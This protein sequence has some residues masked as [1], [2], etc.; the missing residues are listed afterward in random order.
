MLESPTPRVRANAV[1]EREPAKARG[2]SDRKG[3]ERIRGERFR[4]RRRHSVADMSLLVILAAL[5]INV[6][7]D[8]PVLQQPYR[9]LAAIMDMEETLYHAAL[10]AR[11]DLAAH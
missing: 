9:L 7:R 6:Y 1:G 3:T 10:S 5:F 8:H 11:A 2:G 4:Q